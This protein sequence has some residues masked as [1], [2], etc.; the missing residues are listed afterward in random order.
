MGH[1]SISPPTELTE[2]YILFNEDLIGKKNT[3]NECKVVDK[4]TFMSS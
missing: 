2:K 3:V 1:R 4:Y